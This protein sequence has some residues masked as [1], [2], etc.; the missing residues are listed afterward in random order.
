[1]LLLT[2]EASFSC[3]KAISIGIKE[4]HD[5]ENTTA[6]HGVPKGYGRMGVMVVYKKRVVG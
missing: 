1:M 6:H 5:N 4:D 3:L 2:R